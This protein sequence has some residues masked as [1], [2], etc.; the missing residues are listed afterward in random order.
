MGTNPSRSNPPPDAERS[1][2]GAPAAGGTQHHGHS[3]RGAGTALARLKQWERSRATLGES[4]RDRP[5]GDPPE[6]A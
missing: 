6:R 4:R 3:G 2:P 1:G 5:A